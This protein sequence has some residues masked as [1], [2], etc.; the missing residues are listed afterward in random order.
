MGGEAVGKVGYHRQLVC[1]DDLLAQ[2]HQEAAYPGGAV[3]PGLPA[4]V[5]LFRHRLVLDDGTGDELGEEGDVQ[6]HF[7]R[8]ALDL[9]PIPVHI[10]HIAHGLEGEK[11]D[12][13]GELDHRDGEGEPQPSQ[14]AQHKGEVLEDKHQSQVGGHREDQR[15]TGGLSTALLGVDPQAEGIVDQDRGHHH[16]D[17]PGLTPG[18]EEKGA[19]QQQ[20]IL[21]RA[22][23]PAQQAAGTVVA[24]QHQRQEEEEK[25]GTGKQ[26]ASGLLFSENLR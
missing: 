14:L 3:L 9:A 26:H 12:A 19:H 18:V 17:E 8:I 1:Q 7:Q 11:G 4:A 25:D 21:G 5:D 20:Q 24:Q 2:A 22:A 6:G 13:E 10:Q 16:Q 15:Y 23:P